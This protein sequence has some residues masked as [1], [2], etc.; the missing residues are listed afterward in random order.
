[1]QKI[2]LG[3]TGKR[4]SSMGLGTMYFGT[5]VDVHTSFKLLD[6]YYDAGGNFIDTANKY[7]SWVPGC[8][9]GES[10]ALI[11]SWMKK[12]R[13]REGLFISTKVG[14]AYRDV[15]QSLKAKH[16]IDECEKSLKRLGVETIDLYFAHTYDMDTPFEESLEAFHKLQ[17]DGKIRYIGASNYFS[18][19]LERARQIH[20]TNGW[21]PFCCLQQKYTLLQP[22]VGAYFGNQKVLTPDLSEYCQLHQLSLMAYSPLLSGAYSVKEKEI[23][24]QYKTGDSGKRLKAL[25]EITADTGFTP[26]QIVLAWMLQQNPPVLPLVTGSNEGQLLENICAGSLSLSEDH[27]KRLSNSFGAVTPGLQEGIG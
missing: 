23:P 18:W 8:K 13:N 16:I 7:A 6:T 11:G 20:S 2:K 25:G 1:M 21:K 24:G 22:T 5:K 3:N 14:F 12:R 19:H 27:K 26:N 17:G 4:I 9:G 10:E 15:P